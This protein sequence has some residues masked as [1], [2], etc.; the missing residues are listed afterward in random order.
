[1]CFLNKEAKEVNIFKEIAGYLIVFISY[2][3]LSD[4]IMINISIKKSKKQF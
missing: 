4:F 2:N 3:N 1:M